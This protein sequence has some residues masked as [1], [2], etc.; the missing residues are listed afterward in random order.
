MKPITYRLR[1]DAY[2]NECQAQIH[3]KQFDTGTRNLSAVL[4]LDDGVP[5]DMT[6]VA[7]ATLYAKRPDGLI[8]LA[9]AEIE[10]GEI[11]LTIPSSIFSA[12]GTA[13]CE[14]TLYD[15]D[16]NQ[17][18]SPRFDIIVED[19]LYD[20]NAM[21]ASDDWTLL[22]Q[23]LAEVENLKNALTI[24]DTYATYA[25]L[26]AAVTDPNVGDTY[27]VGPDS[28]VYDVYTSTETGEWL[29]LGPLDVALEDYPKY[30]NMT[31]LATGA[32]LNSSAFMTA[33]TYIA[34]NSTAATIVNA[35]PLSVTPV[36]GFALL[37]LNIENHSVWQYAW[38]DVQDALYARTYNVAS[39]WTDWK[40]LW[41]LAATTANAMAL[42]GEAEIPASSDLND[43]L[44]A[45]NFY[46]GSANASTITN[47]PTTNA[48]YLLVARNSSGSTYIH[49]YIRTLYGALWY[50]CMRSAGTVYSGWVQIHP[51]PVSTDTLTL[52]DATGNAANHLSKAGNIATLML[53]V[54]LTAAKSSGNTNY[55]A[56]L[57]AG[58]LPKNTQ[59]VWGAS[60][61]NPPTPLYMVIADTGKIYHVG[62]SQASG[63]RIRCEC[64]YVVN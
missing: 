40:K 32:D 41:P 27:A 37:V 19:S 17:L 29:D 60:G 50:R 12:Q 64:S 36:E 21:T 44:S 46:V 63:T 23:K 4:V 25:D 31:A 26:E 57:P 61:A 18:T 38:A 55:F 62:T 28:G 47:S 58:F 43:Y 51:T 2:S 6:D 1:L 22:V 56:E 13:E 34:Y 49:Q 54:E 16:S 53:D 39:T 15:A 10:A 20:E 45:G 48:F 7:G 8:T 35:P 24:I 11:K 3:A 42:T 33:G 5:Y 9:A 30:Q 14:L 52:T 59:M